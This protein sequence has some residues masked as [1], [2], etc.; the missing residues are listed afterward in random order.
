MKD[1]ELEAFIE[2]IESHLKARR[3][4][5]HIL[6]PRDFALARSWYRGGLPLATVLVGMDRAFARSRDLTSLASCRRSVEELAASGPAPQR[7]TAPLPES[8]PV[9][10]VSE[11]LR[12][13]HERL[14]ALPPLPRAV[15]E[16]PLRKIMEVRDLLAV[17]SRP[18]WSY[19]RGKLQ[20]IDDDVSA[21]ALETLPQTESEGL[22]LEASRA[23]ERYRGRIHEAALED[24]KARFVVQRARERLGLL[25]VNLL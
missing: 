6:S 22:Q 5:D 10:E 11:L 8:V 25:R 1:P 15:F 16:P 23:V 20:E 17:A 3:G 18:N 12:S 21:A 13:L 7:R 9:S 24:A 2:A 14:W 19:L 4:V